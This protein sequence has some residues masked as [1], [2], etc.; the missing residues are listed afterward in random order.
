MASKARVP[1]IPMG[2]A[3]TYKVWPL[4]TRIPRRGKITIRIGEAIIPAWAP[5]RERQSA[6]TSSVMNA[7]ALLSCGAG[8]PSETSKLT[9]LPAAG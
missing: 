9:G 7:I 4:G 5:T 3:G 6:F 1:I 2:I 8:A